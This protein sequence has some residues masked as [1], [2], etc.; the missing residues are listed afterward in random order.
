MP[1]Q[2]PPG[3]Y[4]LLDTLR[5]CDN[6]RYRFP[7]LVDPGSDHAPGIRIDA[8]E[9]SGHVVDLAVGMPEGTREGKGHTG[10]ECRS[11]GARDRRDKTASIIHLSHASPLPCFRVVAPDC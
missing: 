11:R 5:S 10:L 7:V 2:T 4:E 3:V 6:L 9:L 8:G 1:P